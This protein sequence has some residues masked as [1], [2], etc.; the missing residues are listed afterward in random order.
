M[1]RVR[2]VQLITGLVVRSQGSPRMTLSLR[3]M[4]WKTTFWVIPSMLVKRVQE[5]RMSPFLLRD[6][7]AFQERIGSLSFEIGRQ[8]FLTKS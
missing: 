2:A 6:P 7:L 5:Y 3:D 1:E 8:C 4:T